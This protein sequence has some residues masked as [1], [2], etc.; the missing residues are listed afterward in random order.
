[1][2]RQ[3]SFEPGW[4]G[5]ENGF[6]AKKDANCEILFEAFSRMV[7]KSSNERIVCVPVDQTVVPE[8]RYDASGAMSLKSG[9][10]SL[11]AGMFGVF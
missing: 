11:K 9:I 2:F 7:L 6:D 4:Q 8:I 3:R 10:S 1:V 5:G